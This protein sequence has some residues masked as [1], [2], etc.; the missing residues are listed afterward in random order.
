MGFDKDL[1]N[2]LSGMSMVDVL[3]ESQLKG[4]GKT[5]IKSSDIE[6]ILS[7]HDIDHMIIGAHALGEIT[8]EPRATQDVDVVVKDEDFNKTIELL[9]SNY[10]FAHADDNRIKDQNN[11]VLIDVLTDKH[12]IY[13]A[14]MTVG[15]RIPEPEMVLVMKFLSNISPLRRKDKKLQDKADFFNVVSKVDINI[16][17]VMALLKDS[18]PEYDLH[19][20]EIIEWIKEAK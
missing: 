17:K 2:I 20:D 10:P 3:S 12:P 6:D 19:K 16:D 11:N 13:K 5:F 7:S 15:G 18:D 4:V 8:K 14:A 1:D 9:L